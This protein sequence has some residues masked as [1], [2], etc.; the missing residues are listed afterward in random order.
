M[1]NFYYICLEIEREEKDMILY[2]LFAMLFILLVAPTAYTLIVDWLQD[3]KY[4]KELEA[5][6]EPISVY[7]LYMK[8]ANTYSEKEL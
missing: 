1:K 4:I 5:K 6:S 7:E 8:K 3:R 2:V